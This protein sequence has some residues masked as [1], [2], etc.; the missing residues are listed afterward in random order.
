QIP[1]AEITELPEPDPDPQAALEV[2]FEPFPTSL[3]DDLR[4]GRPEIT[5]N[6]P[7][8]ASSPLDAP[9]LASDPDRERVRSLL[10]E[11][12]QQASSHHQR[13]RWLML[14]VREKVRH[15]LSQLQQRELRIS[16]GPGEASCLLGFLVDAE[17][18]IFDITLRPAP[19]LEIDAFAIRDA[20]ALLNPIKAPPPGV[21][22]PIHLQLRVDFLE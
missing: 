18:W 13:D 5:P 22:T 4:E 3:E 14:E 2:P 20:I 6:P 17:G 7:A 11:T 12:M 21:A 19:G 1:E 8:A 16:E 10:E 15:N 9:P